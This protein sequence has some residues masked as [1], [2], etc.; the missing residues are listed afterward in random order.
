[1]GGTTGKIACCATQS[2]VV[3]RVI[4]DEGRYSNHPDD[5]GGATKYGISQFIWKAAAQDV[6]GV[7]PNTTSVSTL[8]EA[9]AKQ[10][11]DAI[12]WSPSNAKAISQLDG[13]LATIFFNFYVNTPR[14]AGKALQRAL[15]GSG[16]SVTVDGVIGSASLD[17][18]KDAIDAGKLHTVHNKFKDEMQSHYNDRV[19][20]DSTQSAFINGWTNRVNDF[21]DKANSSSRN[22]H[23]Q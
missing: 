4:D 14:G 2:K 1:M 12:Y 6:L 5:K 21:S 10:I 22:V 13:D 16:Q 3:D 9:Q 8:T 11:Y 15:N 17:A 23:C 18:I 20:K 19:A 7:N